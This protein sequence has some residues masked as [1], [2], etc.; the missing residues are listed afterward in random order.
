[1]AQRRL[2]RLATATG[3]TEDAVRFAASAQRIQ[4]QALQT[5]ATTSC[6]INA[7]HSAT[8]ARLGTDSGIRSHRHVSVDSSTDNRNIDELDEDY[9]GGNAS[10]SCFLDSPQYAP[11]ATSATASAT[12]AFARLPGTAQG[13]LELVPFLR[14]RNAR[15]GVAHGVEV[16]GWMAGF[17]M[18][19]VYAAA[20][21]IAEGALP[22][23]LVATAVDWAYNDVLVARGNNS[24]IGMLEQNATMTM[25]S[26]TQPPWGAGGGGTFSHP[27]TAS[28]SYVIPRFLMGVRP[29]AP[30]WS[31]IA[32]RP[33]PPRR[34]D[35]QH[36]SITVPTPRGK[37]LLE[38]DIDSAVFSARLVVPGNTLAHVCLP[39]YLFPDDEKCVFA[40]NGET[41]AVQTDSGA[42]TCAVDELGSGAYNMTLSC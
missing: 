10:L 17:M 41:R 5:F 22:L 1:M 28:P 37:V 42:L 27:W 15:R 14:A 33:L 40:V 2:A 4:Q 19:G 29:L 11:R 38:F 36:A 23:D 30:G 31:R 9:I 13:V 35:L 25:E 39:R 3:H 18:E 20:G 7:T 6:S 21:E 32:I 26:W 8:S 12:A 24:W 16:S 34:S